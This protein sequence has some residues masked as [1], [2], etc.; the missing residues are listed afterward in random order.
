LA[1]VQFAAPLE[2][3]AYDNKATQYY[4]DI[5]YHLEKQDTPIGALDMPIAAHALS[6]GC[7]L[8]PNNEREFNRVPKLRIENWAE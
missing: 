8:V 6:E 4:R 2:I 1:L 7:I 5:R 3:L